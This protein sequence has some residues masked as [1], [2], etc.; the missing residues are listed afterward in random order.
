MKTKKKLKNFTKVKF[1]ILILTLYLFTGCAS[2]VVSIYNAEIKRP[3][4]YIIKLPNTVTSSDDK[5]TGLDSLLQQII[6]HSLKSKG[7]QPS[8]LPDLYVSYT[9]SIHSSSES[10]NKE[11][12]PYSRNTYL[13]NSRN[14]YRVADRNTYS[15][16][17]YKEGVLIINIKNKRGKLHWQGSNTFKLKSK[18]SIEDV[19]PEICQE[20]IDA[21]IPST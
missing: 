21:Y 13:N 4:T 17:T 12:N 5:N 10:Q 2:N 9:I 1:S 11:Y 3:K 8:S 19:L 15:T 6:G 7:I 14:N 16:H 20:I 18:L